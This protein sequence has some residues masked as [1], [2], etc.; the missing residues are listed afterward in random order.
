LLE[1]LA[2]DLPVLEAIQGGALESQRFLPRGN[3]MRSEAWPQL[4]RMLLEVRTHFDRV[5]LALDFA[6]PHEAGPA[7]EGLEA[8][9][10]WCPDDSACILSSALAERIGIPLR[11]I[12]LSMSEDVMH[13]ILGW[14]AGA[15]A[16]DPARSAAPI[17]PLEGTPREVAANR[18][19]MPQVVDC[20]LQ[21]RERLRFLVWMRGV[22]AESHRE[23]EL[24]R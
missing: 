24:Q 6:V 4:G 12:R 20:D 3:P 10:W 9:G 5:V 2:G 19:A 22:Q 23:L 14:R 21:V 15:L 11:N 18:Q 1:C 13:E 8:A 17:S 16:A 7:L